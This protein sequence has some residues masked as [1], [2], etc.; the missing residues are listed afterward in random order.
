MDK[1]TKQEFKKVNG[2]LSKIINQ[3]DRLASF[4]R[5][6]VAL[7]I[8]LEELDNKFA[9]KADVDKILTAVD[10]IAKQTLKNNDELKIVAAK[11][12]RIEGWITDVAAPKLGLKYYPGALGER[13]QET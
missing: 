10:G 3:I 12:T 2:Q 1:E 13:K 9:S 6:H 4:I 8:D 11:T 7:K 5:T